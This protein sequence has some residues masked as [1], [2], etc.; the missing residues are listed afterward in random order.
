MCCIQQILLEL[1]SVLVITAV[2]GFQFI[3]S[4]SLS[5]PNKVGIKCPSVR[6]QNISSI[7]MKF[8]V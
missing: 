1:S 8:G 3:R 2:S 4:T 6:P 5:R 7:S